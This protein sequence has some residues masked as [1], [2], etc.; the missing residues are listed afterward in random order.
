MK[1][2]M[3]AN[4]SAY[5]RIYDV[6]GDLGNVREF[7]DKQVDPDGDGGLLYEM[8]WVVKNPEEPLNILIE[9]PTDAEIELIE[10]T[11]SGRITIT[12]KMNLLGDHPANPTGQEI[13][14]TETG[15]SYRI[16]A[17]INPEVLART[18]KIWFDDQS[19]TPEEIA[20]KI[21]KEG[22]NTSTDEWIEQYG[23][24][25]LE[26]R[27]YPTLVPFSPEVGIFRKEQH[28]GGVGIPG[29]A[30]GGQYLNGAGNGTSDSMLARVSNGEYINTAASTNF[31]GPDFFES[32]NRNM[33]PTSFLN[34][35]GA[36]ASGGGGPQ[37]VTN[38]NVN[39]INPLTRDP[40]KQLRES[41]EMVAA[42]IWS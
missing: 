24:I 42:G 40:L 20:A 15:S 3:E 11:L 7:I 36:A 2:E 31:W 35:L 13:T 28:G 4:E 12:P 16:D 19:Q 25:V 6:T 27:V 22:M 26:A 41:S 37:S 32:L 29:Y 10:N 23:P 1:E 21:N 39:Q 18:T 17:E 33:L 9:D 5:A 34:M 38:V 14:D 30:S 8:E